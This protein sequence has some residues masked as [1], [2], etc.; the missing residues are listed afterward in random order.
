MDLEERKRVVIEDLTAR[1]AGDE[2]P[3][4]EY[5][6][7]VADI[8]GARGPREL[9][10]IEDEFAA[11]LPASARPAARAADPSSGVVAGVY[12]Q[13]EAN[14]QS[15]V[16]IL[17]SRSLRGDWLR[18]PAVS[19]VAIMGSQSIDFREVALPAGPTVLE[20]VAIMGSVD[21]IVPDGLAVRMEASAIMGDAAVGRSVEQRE[22]PGAPVLV[23]TGSAI[24][25]SIGVKAR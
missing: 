8:Q 3:M 11:S 24:M 2:L 18:K 5:E 14:V 15:S 25:G 6:R 9:A 20:A 21:I 17:S 13:S 19:A 7:L 12:I 10:V 23:I 4:E 16:A 1:F 22:R